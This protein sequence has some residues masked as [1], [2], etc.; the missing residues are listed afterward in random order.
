MFFHL[1]PN[2]EQL[3]LKLHAGNLLSKQKLNS[4]NNQN[5]YTESPI[6]CI[7]LQLTKNLP[8]KK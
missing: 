3:L 6:I 7:S 1:L 4:S 2:E 5:N 8:K